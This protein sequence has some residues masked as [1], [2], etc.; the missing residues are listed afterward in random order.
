MKQTVDE[1]VKHCKI[2]QQ[3]KHENTKPPGLLQPLLVLYG[4]WIDLSMDF[5]AGLPKSDDFLVIMVAVDRFTKYAHFL[6]IKH[7]FTP[8]SIAQVFFNNIVK[9]HGFPRQ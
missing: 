7:P 1:Y 4:S 6:W 9:L 5:I 8:A 3:A 2:W